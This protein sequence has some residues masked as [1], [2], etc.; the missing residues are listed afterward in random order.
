MSHQE[1][2]C[3][4]RERE[5]ERERERGREGGRE[6]GGRWSLSSVRVLIPSA[7]LEPKG[8]GRGYGFHVRFATRMVVFF[9]T[10]AATYFALHKPFFFSLHPVR[11]QHE[12][13]VGGTELGAAHCAPSFWREVSWRH[14]N[15]CCKARQKSTI[16][17][18]EV[19]LGPRRRPV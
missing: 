5:R 3:M 8:V 13:L 18:F 16:S 6:G 17:R 4:P 1:A 12:G 7:L 11:Q 2:Y 10:V 15:C 19:Q 9:P 14:S